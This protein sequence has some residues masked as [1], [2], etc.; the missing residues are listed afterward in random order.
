MFEYHHSDPFILSS[1][2][3]Y[4]SSLVTFALRI[5]GTLDPEFLDQCQIT[6]KKLE[7]EIQELKPTPIQ[8]EFLSSNF[9]Y[10]EELFLDI[11]ISYNKQFFHSS[12]FKQYNSWLE[13]QHQW[14][15]ICPFNDDLII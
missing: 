13:Y 5:G 14:N 3:P 9:N 1:L 11:D 7:K 2:C 6:D 12:Q 8:Y 15:I 10:Q 4:S